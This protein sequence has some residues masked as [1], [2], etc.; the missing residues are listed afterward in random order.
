MAVNVLTSTVLSQ[1]GKELRLT[2]VH[3]STSHLK[4]SRGLSWKK[5][6][7][8]LN[9]VLRF[10]LILFWPLSW[11][12]G[13][14]HYWQFWS[15]SALILLLMMWSAGTLAILKILR[16]RILRLSKSKSTREI[17][18][19]MPISYSQGVAD[20]NFINDFCHQNLIDYEGQLSS[21]FTTRIFLA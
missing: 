19:K 20:L 15:F 11:L 21:V 10:Q 6:C 16:C 3:E 14:L 18:H 9:F 12:Q 5:V 4:M 1:L 7:R 17:A 2:V 8:K 13:Q